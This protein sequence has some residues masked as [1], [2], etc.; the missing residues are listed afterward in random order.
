[1]VPCKERL[2][3]SETET[4]VNWVNSAVACLFFLEDVFVVTDKKLPCV[5]SALNKFLQCSKKQLKQEGTIYKKGYQIIKMV[6]KLQKRL[7]KCENGYQF[8]EV[9]TNL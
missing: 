1:M 6:I 4:G 3:S 7:P 2:D 5:N 8:A 9:V